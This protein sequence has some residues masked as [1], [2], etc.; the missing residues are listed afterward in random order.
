ME[1]IFFKF[2]NINISA[3]LRSAEL[4]VKEIFLKNFILNRV[5]S[6][7]LFKFK[8]EKKRKRKNLYFL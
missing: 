7:H 5:R 3:V 6:I 4:R 2:I 8:F 1:I